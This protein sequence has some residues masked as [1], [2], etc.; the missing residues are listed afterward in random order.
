MQFVNVKHTALAVGLSLLC[1]P[2]AITV[3][4]AQR[5]VDT[6]AT[7]ALSPQHP[8]VKNDCVECHSD[9]KHTSVKVALTAE[10]TS[11]HSAKVA[12]SA[13]EQTQPPQGKPVKRFPDEK[14]LR[15]FLAKIGRTAPSSAPSTGTV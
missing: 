9:P 3:T 2:L 4:A 15:A 10:C 12:L 8:A 11:C 13:V 14:A 1:L 7:V 6:P 5:G